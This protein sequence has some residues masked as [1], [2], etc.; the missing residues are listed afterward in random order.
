LP[1][2][3]GSTTTTYRREAQGGTP[4]SSDDLLPPLASA[5]LKE[6]VVHIDKV[7]ALPQDLYESLMMA[8]REARSRGQH[9]LVSATHP[10]FDGGYN[11]SSCKRRKDRLVL[12][13]DPPKALRQ[14]DAE[15]AM[16]PFASR[17]LAQ[18][19]QL[20]NNENFR[21]PTLLVSERNRLAGKQMDRRPVMA[22]TH[23]FQV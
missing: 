8:G 13:R 11:G 12:P 18:Q 19:K 21:Q 5:S 1:K 10:A 22:R 2:R 15:V 3:R 7:T 23:G 20:P 9:R 16:R 4:P 14:T 6:K 17:C